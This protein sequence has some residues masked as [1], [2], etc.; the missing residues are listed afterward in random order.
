VATTTGGVKLMRVYAL[1]GLGTKEMSRLLYPSAIGQT[2]TRGLRISRDGAQI[3]WVFFMLY[4][5]TLAAVMTALGLSGVEFEDA[6]ILAVS[7]LSTTG[8]LATYAGQEAISITSLGDG[9]K[10]VL[11]I[12]MVIGRVE[13]LALISLLNPEFWRN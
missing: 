9:A 3:A 5:L 7:A 11:L 1:F 6:T 4:A 13:A 12:T 10:W 2:G 8:P